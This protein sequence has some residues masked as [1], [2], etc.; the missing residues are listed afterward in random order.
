[1]GDSALAEVET[2]TRRT[3]AIVTGLVAAA[4]PAAAEWPRHR[5]KPCPLP[6]VPYLPYRAGDAAVRPTIT[7]VSLSRIPALPANATAVPAV[8]PDSPA[9]VGAPLI[10]QFLEPRLQIDHC[11]LSRIAVTLHPDGRYQISLRADQNPLPGDADVRSPLRPGEVLNIPLQTTQLR[12]NL[13]IVKVRGYAH[14]QEFAGR[15]SLVPSQPA[16]FELP[17][18]PFWVQRGEPYSGL[19]EGRHEAIRQFLPL[20]DR[21]EVEFTYR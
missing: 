18:E 16:L 1:V 10:Y 7:V 2:M 15:S 11:F 21:V 3:A 20:I 17:V 5:A 8:V 12:R 14:F 6:G 19:F 9:L 13:F 4:A